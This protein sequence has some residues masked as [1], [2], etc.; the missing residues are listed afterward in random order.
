LQAA[1]V[2]ALAHNKASFLHMDALAGRG[3]RRSGVIPPLAKI[4]AHLYGQQLGYQW[5]I[6]PYVTRLGVCRFASMPQ[7]MATVARNVLMGLTA[8]RSL[9]NVTAQTDCAADEGAPNAHLLTRRANQ[10]DGSDSP[11]KQRDRPQPGGHSRY[12]PHVRRWKVLIECT[13]AARTAPAVRV[14]AAAI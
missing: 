1:I 4:T 6:A 14:R 3:F 13:L 11:K 12:Q 10:C 5:Q 2:A 9:P 8:L 7:F